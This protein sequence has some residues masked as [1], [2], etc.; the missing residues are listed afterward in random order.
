[1]RLCTT[2]LFCIC[3]LGVRA[4]E[5]FTQH[6]TRQVAGEGTV[7][8]HQDPEIEA[9]VNNP[10]KYA[11]QHRFTPIGRSTAATDSTATVEPAK[12]ATGHRAYTI[13]YR[14]QVYA[15]GNNRQS[16]AEAHRMANLVRSTFSDIPVYTKFN[17]PRW[18]CQA[19]DFKTREEAHEQLQ[20]MR[21]TPYF[22]EASIVKSKIAVYY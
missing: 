22:G 4:Q 1:M 19:G 13:G 16:K 17:S 5:T 20:K 2:I 12:H 3:F 6:L 21:A 18:V 10:S 9:L 7:V 14:I 15:G 11:S 8:L